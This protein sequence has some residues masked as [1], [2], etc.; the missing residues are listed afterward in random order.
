MAKHA[1]VED[2]RVLDINRL[3]KLGHIKHGERSAGRMTWGKLEVRLEH[4]GNDA[5]HVYFQDGR[6]QK[7]RVVRIAIPHG[8]HRWL[9]HLGNRRVVKLFMPRGGDI[10]KSRTA[11]GLRYRCQHL[12]QKN[13]REARVRKQYMRHG[14]IFDLWRPKGWWRT[15]HERRVTELRLLEHRARMYGRNDRQQALI[16]A[17]ASSGPEGTMAPGAR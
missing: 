13:R 4:N 9:F 15:T 3:V 17:R 10:F 16:R 2:A 6:T 7:L 12:S 1:F 14:A 5:L 8:G 11:W